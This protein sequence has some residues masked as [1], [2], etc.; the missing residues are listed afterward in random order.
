MVEFQNNMEEDDG[1]SEISEIEPISPSAQQCN[2]TIPVTHQAPAGKSEESLRN[3][4][5]HVTSSNETDESENGDGN[6]SMEAKNEGSS[7]NVFMFWACFVGIVSLITL[8]FLLTSSLTSPENEK[9]E[10]LSMPPD[11][12]SHYFKGKMVKVQIGAEERHSIQVFVREEGPRDAE[13]VFLVHGFGGSSFSFREVISIL[14][15]K[16]IHAVAVDLP[17]FGFSDKSSLQTDRRWGGL[18][19]RVKDVYLDIKEK[20]LFWG[21]DQLVETGEMPYVQYEPRVTKSYQVLQCGA[22]ELSQSLDQVIGSLSLGPVHLVVHD[23]GFETGAVW[24]TSNPSLVRSITLIDAAPRNPSVPSWFLKVPGVGELVTHF[25][26]LQLG[27]LRTCCSKSMDISVA[28]AHVILLRTKNGRRAYAEIGSRANASFDLKAWADADLVKEVPMQI[29]WGNDWSKD[30]QREGDQIAKVL[31][32][33]VFVPHSG[34]R[35]PQE[36]AAKEI[37]EALASFISSVPPTVRTVTEEALPE[38]IQKMFDEV[39][40]DHHH[41]HSDS[42]LHIHTHQHGHDHGDH[43]HSHGAGYMDGYGLAHGGWH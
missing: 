39:G 17:G 18:I 35:W 19:G 13:T 12:R 10:F 15:S 23:T 27:M 28:E 9:A 38:H 3:R 14:A 24:A 41:S 43:G 4:R 34:G 29:L 21:F 36:D 7:P 42:H 31:P 8:F 32:R 25:P 16:G 22:Q 37:A 30:W 11:L 1:H 5:R 20:G 2:D 40:S 6:P 26:L 33:A